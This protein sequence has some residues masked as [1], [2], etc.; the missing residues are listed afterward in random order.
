MRTTAEG[1]GAA[2]AKSIGPTTGEVTA[3]LRSKTIAGES[4]STIPDVAGRWLPGSERERFGIRESWVGQ[5]SPFNGSGPGV[6]DR[7][8]T[9]DALHQMR[10]ADAGSTGRQA[11]PATEP[12]DQT[13]EPL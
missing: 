9:Q 7:A 3:E 5:E 8:R 10:I 6:G 13:A 12:R 11:G 2:V 4:G 1:A